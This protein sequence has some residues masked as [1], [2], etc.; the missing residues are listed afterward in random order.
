MHRE[1]NV[2]IQ[3]QKRPDQ[4]LHRSGVGHTRRVHENHLG[5]PHV[6]EFEQKPGD[7][8]RG[9]AARVRASK[10]RH[11]I[12]PHASG[13]SHR[14]VEKCREHLVEALFE[15]LADVD[16]IERV[17]GGKQNQQFVDLGHQGPPAADFIGHQAYVGHLRLFGDA[18]DKLFRVVPLRQQTR[19][20]KGSALDLLQARFG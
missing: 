20:R 16:A 18:G 9:N 1:L 12:N 7:L 3:I 6:I 8:P 17:A 15:G 13:V 19:M 5:R 10:G 2:Q 11:H 4:F 14:R